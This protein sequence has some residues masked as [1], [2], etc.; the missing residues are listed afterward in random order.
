MIKRLTAM[1]AALILIFA[2]GA[3]QKKEAWGEPVKEPVAEAKEP[4]TATK[5]LEPIR[6]K[7]VR[8]GN[9]NDEGSVFV[10]EIKQEGT[11][12]DVDVPATALLAIGTIGGEPEPEPEP[13][14]EP[15]LDT[16][17][18][19][20]SPVAPEGE[21]SDT[22][23][24]SGGDE[25]AEQDVVADVGQDEVG[26]DPEP[27]PT[28]EP[29]PEPAPEPE[30]AVEEPQPEPEW[31]YYG[32]VHVTHYCHCSICNGVA[33]N[34]TASGEWPTVNHTVATGPDI[35]FYTEIMINGQV[36]VVEDRGVGEGCVDIFVEDHQLALNLG[37]YWA[38]MYVRW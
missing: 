34:Y 12:G 10:S 4:E 33:G 7:E 28:P 21:P 11:A 13:V 17:T 14:P 19:E 38:D 27:E 24:Y 6:P 25:D 1:A 37:E 22:E 32:A 16:T 8:N 20:G 15:E 36:Y 23:E 29:A 31:S 2:V 9:R 35:P 3:N 18:D 30:P 5:Q 26:T